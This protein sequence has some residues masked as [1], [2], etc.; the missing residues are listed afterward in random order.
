MTSRDPRFLTALEFAK[1]ER[2]AIIFRLALAC[3]LSFA[4]GLAVGRFLGG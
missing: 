1:I 3:M 4:A 2:R